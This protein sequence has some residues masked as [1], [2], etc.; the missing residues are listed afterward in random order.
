MDLSKAYERL[1]LDLMVAK[2]E[3]YGLAKERLQLISE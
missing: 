1:P 3:T 2:P